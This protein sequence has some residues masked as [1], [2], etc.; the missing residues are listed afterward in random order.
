MLL[1]NLAHNL[2]KNFA[3]FICSKRPNIIIEKLLNQIKI[4]L[5]ASDNGNWD[6]KTN[7]EQR[8]LYCLQLASPK[9]ILDVGANT[10]D[11]SLMARNLFPECDIHSFEIVPD[12]FKLL[13]ENTKNDKKI[14]SN[15]VGL[16][17]ESGKI[18][19]NSS[20]SSSTTATANKIE[21][22]S[23]H[24]VYYDKNTECDVITGSDYI[25]E[26]N[27]SI[28]DFLKIDVEGMELKVL[29]GF[30]DNLKSIRVIQFEY[31][32]FNIS[33]R[34]LLIDFFT[35]LGDHDFLIGKIY[36]KYV[37]FFEY[38]FSRE[39]FGGHNYLAVKSNESALISQFRYGRNLI[40]KHAE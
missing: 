1:K 18:I 35:L 16:S 13:L 10:G 2:N 21:G 22:L 32:I 8:V 25:K 6:F 36:P 20:S 5:K 11:W 3:K 27:I 31:G 30:G 9:L 34:D 23:Y 29:E 37:D 24:D 7:G 26:H 28:V 12:T 14:F 19:I 4:F 15:C 39:D 38:H 17:N 40:T 33:S